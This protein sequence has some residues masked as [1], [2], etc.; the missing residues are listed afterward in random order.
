MKILKNYTISNSS[1]LDTK[2]KND[3]P[4]LGKCQYGLYWSKSKILITSKPNWAIW[5][6]FWG[7]MAENWG[8]KNHQKF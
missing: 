5:I 6:N 2:A 7:Q 3:I 1:K 8:F 4:M